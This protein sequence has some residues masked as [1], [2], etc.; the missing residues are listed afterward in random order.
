[1]VIEI[2]SGSVNEAAIREVTEDVYFTCETL[3][4]NPRNTK[5]IFRNT[6]EKRSTIVS[7]ERSVETKLVKL[8]ENCDAFVEKTDAI[9]SFNWYSEYV[10]DSKLPNETDENGHI[11]DD[12]RIDRLK[13]F[14]YGYIL[15]TNKSVDEQDEQ[16]YLELV[17]LRNKLDKELSASVNRFGANNGVQGSGLSASLLDRM[18]S[19]LLKRCA[20][21]EY[22][23]YTKSLTDLLQGAYPDAESREADKDI[24]IDW[25][26]QFMRNRGLSDPQL[27]QHAV[28]PFNSRMVADLQVYI[29]TLTENMESQF[30]RTKIEQ[31]CFP[32]VSDNGKL[33]APGQNDLFDFLLNR[34]AAGDRLT[35]M[36]ATSRYEFARYGG[37]IFKEYRGD[38]WES[39]DSRKYI[40]DLITNL[41]ENESFDLAQTEEL[42]LKSFAAF[43]KKGDKNEME[44]FYDYLTAHGTSDVRIAFAIWGIVFGFA[45]LPKTVTNELFRSGD[46]E[47]ISGVYKHIHRQLH[48]KNLSDDSM[49]VG[50]A[51]NHVVSQ[52]E[53]KQNPGVASL[54]AGQDAGADFEV[55]ILDKLEE[56]EKK[57]PKGW[58]P[59]QKETTIKVIRESAALATTGT[60]FFQRIDT[61]EPIMKSKRL[62]PY[63]QQEVDGYENPSISL[64]TS[65]ANLDNTKLNS[66]ERHE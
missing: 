48:G 15:G 50:S 61:Y 53:S 28:R 44:S 64:A 46:S 40:N 43:C 8:Y 29:D 27:V 9:K 33:K 37:G 12:I 23:D 32:S 49:P 51:S 5:F 59:E 16:D 36:I 3:Y 17:N 58:S 4:L 60:D 65:E 38:E 31:A 34:L 57:I 14:L 19:I 52:P 1:M 26:L 56:V 7:S 39:S 18:N 54:K 13:G 45:A 11:K 25:L 20:R 22:S 47:Y 10:D 62:R 30:E 24:V 42:V 6:E 66:S 21:K 2:E 55:F 63:L 41:N 35:E